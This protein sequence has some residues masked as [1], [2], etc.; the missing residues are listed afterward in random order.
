MAGFESDPAIPDIHGDSVAVVVDAV[1][2]VIVVDSFCK[3][4]VSEKSHDLLTLF[5]HRLHS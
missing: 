5:A 4:L 3:G 2:A 1:V